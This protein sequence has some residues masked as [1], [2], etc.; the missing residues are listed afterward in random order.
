ME[1]NREKLYSINKHDLKYFKKDIDYSLLT[2]QGKK[3]YEEHNTKDI[4]SIDYRIKE[5]NEVKERNEDEYIDLSMLSLSHIPIT[6]STTLKYLFISSNKLT[7]LG[8]LSHLINLEALDCS[9]NNLNSLDN[10]PASLTEL[11][12]KYNK[13]TM[14]NVS[15]L[16]CLEILDC[17]NNNISTLEYGNSLTQLD[18][19]NNKLTVLNKYNSLQTLTVLSCE[20]NKLE[21]IPEYPNL[22]IL[23]CSHNKITSIDNLPHLEELY[24]DNNKIL[25]INGINEIHTISCMENPEIT[26]PYFSKLAEIT[27]TAKQVNV[28]RRYNVLNIIHFGNEDLYFFKTSPTS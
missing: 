13:L 22:K 23:N 8:N 5:Y 9:N 17:G 4:G 3:V 21:K 14:L 1:P 6:L 28:S 10:L 24:C 2:P 18:C 7:S 15:N 19:N 11:V 20:F 26:I 12:C 25:R 16:K 27:C